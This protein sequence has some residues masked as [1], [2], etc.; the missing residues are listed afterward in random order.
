[1]QSSMV[2][3]QQWIS[4]YS[5]LFTKSNSRLAISLLATVGQ[6]DGSFVA[7]PLPGGLTRWGEHCHGSRWWDA[8]FLECLFSRQV[9]KGR[10]SHYLSFLIIWNSLFCHYSYLFNWK[11]NSLVLGF[12]KILFLILK[13][14]S[15]GLS[16]VGGDVNFFCHLSLSLEKPSF[17]FQF[18]RHFSSV[19][20]VFKSRHSDKLSSLVWCHW[21]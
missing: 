17:H 6:V 18:V 20:W 10:A 2:G 12:L 15:G 13:R 1:M 5:R 8:A 9:S 21:M 16:Q 4:E 11:G 19:Y 3:A 7:C 14:K